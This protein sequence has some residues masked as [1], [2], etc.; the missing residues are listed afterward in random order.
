MKRLLLLVVPVFLFTVFSCEKDDY[1][2]E[3]FLNDFIN[4]YCERWEECYFDDFK[5]KKANTS[6]CQKEI[7]EQL[8]EGGGFPK[9]SDTST[10][11]ATESFGINKDGSIYACRG[12]SVSF[13]GENAKAYLSCEKEASCNK[14]WETDDCFFAHS[15]CWITDQTC[16]GIEWSGAGTISSRQWQDA[17]DF[18][19]AMGA[20]LPSITELRKII[21]NCPGS[22]YGGACQVSDPDCLVSDCL[23]EECRCDGSAESYSALGDGKNVWL[24]SSSFLENNPDMAWG[25]YFGEGSLNAM[26]RQSRAPTKYNVQLRCVR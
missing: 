25:V 1:A 13:D 22:T 3:K 18:C 17:A 4:L 26:S 8:E 19:T 24:W 6:N 11:N 10:K 21:I 9:P 5:D 12:K 20:R 16:P 15:Y 7:R 2:Q 23:S 14:F